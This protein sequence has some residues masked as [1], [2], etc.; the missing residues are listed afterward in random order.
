MN[1]YRL[2]TDK[3]W[4]ETLQD[5]DTTMRLWGVQNWKATSG[6]QQSRTGLKDQSAAERKV[7]LTFTR[8]GRDVV[9]TMD[10]QARAVDNLRVLYLAVDAMRLNE[11]RGV[12]EVMQEAYVQLAALPA[13]AKQRSSYEIL[14][15]REDSDWEVV[16]AAYRAKARKTH[17][18]SGGS[19]AAF[20]EINEAYEEIKR[21]R[22]E[23]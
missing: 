8:N 14:G 18:D 23:K 13:P 17:P 4:A 10:R 9:L 20:R 21:L 22:G 5:L 12:G 6:I 7:T 3:S 19:A 1:D 16:E 15:V 2:S 11:R